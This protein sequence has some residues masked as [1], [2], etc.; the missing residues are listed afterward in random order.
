M[1]IARSS[2][3][4]I[5]ARMRREFGRRVVRL[6]MERNLAQVDLARKLRIDRSRLGKWERGLH[7]P[8]FAQLVDLAQVLDATLDE[9]LTGRKPAQLVEKTKIDREALT[10]LLAALNG[11]L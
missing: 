8:S 5:E 7:S 10:S 11:L 3:E 9:L 6:R 2:D 4:E 1:V